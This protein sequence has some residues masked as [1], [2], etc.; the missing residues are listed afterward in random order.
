MGRPPKCFPLV[1]VFIL[2]KAKA[3]Q[4]SVP[5]VMGLG[6]VAKDE[7]GTK[8]FAQSSCVTLGY[9]RE[10]TVNYSGNVFW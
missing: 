5:H 1:D 7:E 2:S 10:K 8:A 9:S 3:A 4:F 6:R